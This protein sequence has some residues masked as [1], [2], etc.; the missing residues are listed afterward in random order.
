MT[1]RT[2]VQVNGVEL[3]VQTFGAPSDAAVL[4]LGGASSSMDWW[5]EDFCEQLAA[6]GRYVIRYD[7]RDTGESTSSPAGAPDYRAD[8]LLADIVALLDALQIERA[9]VVGLSMG[10][11]MAQWLALEH[12]ERLASLT[13]IATSP[14]PDSDL[15]P[16]APRI[17][18]LFENPPPPP[19]WSNPDAVVE[20]M[21]EEHRPYAG[22]LGFDADD[23]RRV[24]TIVVDRT[25][26]PEAS[27]TNHWLLGGGD[28]P[29]RP[30]LG[31]IQA[32]T[33]VI[34]GTDD[35][36]FPLPHGQAL[37]REIPDARLVTVQG[38]GHEFP[39][40]PAW[41]QVIDELLR[42]SE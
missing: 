21:V 27:A 34:H 29:L 25:R 11:G 12:P 19:D 9:H 7:Q 18:E 22:E 2:T 3:C 33:L 35:P 24:A 30:R 32:P 40:R 23:V 14:G 1:G 37:A 38:M 4:L 6:G 17:A 13:L 8:D 26:D 16:A 41:D 15:P 31:E 28:E 20:H 5:R 42:H 39:P 36:M 10:G